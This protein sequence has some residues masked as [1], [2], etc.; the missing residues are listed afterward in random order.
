MSIFDFMVLAQSSG[1][2]GAVVGFLVSQ[3]I[4]LAIG[5]LA[6]AGLW[7][8]FVKMGEPGWKAIIPLYNIYVMLEKVGKPA[9]WLILFFIPF[10]NLIAGFLV[11]Q[12]IAEGFGKGTGF[13]VGMLLLGFIFFPLLG[14]GDAQWMGGGKKKFA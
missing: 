1:D 13:A 9:W 12:E 8:V 7:M 2:A 10:V 14:F 6:L 5:I 4:Y 3:I 11:F